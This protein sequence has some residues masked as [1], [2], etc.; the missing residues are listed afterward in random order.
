VALRAPDPWSVSNVSERLTGDAASDPETDL[1]GRLALRQVASTLH[2]GLALVAGDGSL[3]AANPVFRALVGDT[4]RLTGVL[5]AL[6][7]PLDP[8]ACPWARVLFGHGPVTGA[9]VGI[10]HGGTVDE[11]RWLRVNAGCADLEDGTGPAAVVTAVDVTSERL[12]AAALEAAEHRFRLAAEHA[13]IGIAIVALDGT[14]LEANDAFCRLLGYGRGEL[15]GITFQA[16]THPDDLALDLAHVEELLAGGAETYRIVKRYLARSGATVWSQLSVA[17]ARDG[18]G[19]PLYFI[20]MVEDV[21]AEREA[22]D[23]LAHQAS[24]DELT[25]LANRATLLARTAES[26]AR[27][28]GTGRQVALLFCDLD[29]FKLVNDSR[30]HEAGDAVLVETAERLLA[31]IRDGDLAAR[32]GGD[33]FVVLCDA[34]PSRAHAE[35]VAQRLIDEITRPMQTAHDVT[36]TV[37]VGIAI[38]EPGVTAPELLRNA[39]AALYR[40][41]ENGRDRHALFDPELIER[42]TRRLGLEHELREA[43]REG[44]LFLDYQPVRRLGDGSIA[45]Y[46]ALVRWAHPVRGVLAPDT[47]LPIAETTDLILEIDR[48]VLLRACDDAVGWG[49]ADAPNV[50]VNVSARHVG[51]GLLPGLVARALTRSGLDPA[52]LTLELT[53]TALLGVTPTATSEL[54]TLVQLGVRLAIDDFGT[55][56]SSLT[57]LV[58]VPAS[59]VKIDRSFVGRMTGSDA[60]TAIIEAVVSLCR[61]L[62]IDVVAE[63]IEDEDQRSMLSRL[64][65]SYGQGFLLGRPGRIDLTPYVAALD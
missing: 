12:A 25:G 31:C 29:H 2:E 54:D 21:T 51:R 56:Y 59:Y 34:L 17:L 15:C 42:A 55:G 37:S 18:A 38:S 20:S 3:L 50:S 48:Y 47:F 30:G 1:L 28:A 27:A 24:H 58:D 52:R 13:P 45:A 5:D 61:A 41:K 19:A 49:G 60:S 6:G 10:T 22:H 39:D 44:L 46:E 33:E 63:G 35:Q 36:M 7:H 11:T 14:L 4:E 40:A 64:G 26:L 8:R 32:L 53:E 43:M 62:N 57:H 16:I 9:V 65:C 23:A